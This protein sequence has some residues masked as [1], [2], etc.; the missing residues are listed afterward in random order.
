MPHSP[1]LFLFQFPVFVDFSQLHYSVLFSVF[2]QIDIYLWFRST[3]NF[4]QLTITIFNILSHCSDQSI[5]EGCKL[6]RPLAN[7]TRSYHFFLFRTESIQSPSW[8]SHSRSSS[9]QSRHHFNGLPTGLW[10]PSF[11]LILHSSHMTDPP[12]PVGSHHNSDLWQ[13][14]HTYELLIVSAPPGGDPLLE[15]W[16]TNLPHK[17]IHEVLQSLLMIFRCSSGLSTVRD[18]LFIYDGVGLESI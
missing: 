7:F 4:H 5:I 15:H 11:P 6:W 17:S 10:L 2:V 12:H 14:C 18:N 3:E 9:K 13:P 1:L 16:T 8:L